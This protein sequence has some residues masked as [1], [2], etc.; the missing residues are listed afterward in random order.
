[1]SIICHIGLVISTDV[2]KGI[3]VAVEDVYPGVE[4]RVYEALVE[5]HEEKLQWHSLWEEYVGSCQELHNCQVQ[6]LHEEYR[7]EG[8]QGT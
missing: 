8:S 5:E 2:D 3:E 6:L 4:H 1:M 7:R